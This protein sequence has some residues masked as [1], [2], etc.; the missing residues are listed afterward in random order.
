MITETEIRLP[1]DVCD[2]ATERVNSLAHRLGVAASSV[3]RAVVVGRSRDAR[4]DS[5]GWWLR[6]GLWADEPFRAEA[7]PPLALRDVRS[8][9]PVVVVGA[10]PA[11]LFA[12]LTLIE[13]GLRPIVLERGTD[14]RAR[15]RA[16][17]GITRAGVVDPDNNYCFGEGGAGTF[18]DGK[19]YT[20]AT[21]RGS[22]RAVLD[23][24]VRHGAP[25][26]ILIDSHPHVGTNRL[27][28]VVQALRATITN[29]GGE[30]RFAT[31]VTDLAFAGGGV[32]GVGAAADDVVVGRG[33]ILA[34]GH[35]A[36]D[37][38]ALLHRR[39]LA[40]EAKPF[41]V[42]VRVEHPQA[43]VD[44]VQ[45]RCRTRPQGLPAASYTFV[46][47]VDGR[48]VFSFCM[49]PGGVICPAAT[50]DDEVVVNGWSPSSRGLR[51]ANAGIVVE[52]TPD[53]LAP[54]RTEG[55]L[56]GIAFQQ[57]LEHAAFA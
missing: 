8:A 38:F 15:R 16:V 9:P 13:R 7:A 25:P 35:S 1:P 32:A 33:V 26:D 42:G 57:A 23:V 44:Q 27:P 50:S 21:K 52:V 40:L 5:H 29:C 24:L 46:H 14:V 41:A 3:A 12:A 19:L 34:T 20:R 2:D 54:Y 45:Y 4:M 6:V 51:F 56:A 48:G 43:L 39:G 37:V 17:A 55:V 49:C 47:Q 18:S 28:Q 10:G 11:G 36:R 30:V 31:R 22:V 53:D